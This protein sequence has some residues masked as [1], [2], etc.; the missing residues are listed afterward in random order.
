ME[1]AGE[2]TDELML[3]LE[4]Q[5]VLA[6]LRASD[7]PAII[8][9]VSVANEVP[10]DRTRR[11]GRG[12][13]VE[14]HVSRV[15]PGRLE[16]ALSLCSRA[17]DF[18]EQHGATNARLTSIVTGGSGTGLFI[19]TW[20]AQ[21]YRAL[22]KITDAFSTEPDGQAIAMTVTNADNPVTEVFSGT[23]SEIPL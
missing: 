5:S 18:V 6:R 12:N 21:N 15:T 22:G 1:A 20:E 17:F 8:E 23:Y 13:V 11:P 14:V 9:Q 4:M 19:A 16:Q 10:L 3:D 2:F 7:A